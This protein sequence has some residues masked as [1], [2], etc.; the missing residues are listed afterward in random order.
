MTNK[1]FTVVAGGSFLMGTD[2]A[3]GYLEDGEGPVHEVILAPF[4]IAPHTVTNKEFGK[5]IKA[6]SYKTDAEK[7]GWSFVF[8]GFLPDNFP[9]TRSVAQT[10]W[11]RQVFGA[12]WNHP[13]GPQSNLKGRADHPVVHVSW[14]DAMNYCEWAGA[15]LP[16]EAE[17]EFAARGG[18]KQNRYPW[19]KEREP[20]GRHNM[21]VWQGKFPQENTK[22]DGFY[23]TA[24]VGSFKPNGY[25]L[26]QTT[27]NVW[28]W[29]SDWF[30]KNYYKNSP[31]E[32]PEGPYH[33]TRKVMRGGSFLCHDS[34]CFRYRVDARSS[35][36]PDASTSNL[37]FR[38][39]AKQD[40][41][42]T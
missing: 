14:N 34:Y 28:E 12:D 23:G 17:W 15:R 16:T 19:G 39:V 40:K 1:K 33:G 41:I 31:K 21:N 13:E 36:E 26:Y 18:L 29:C 27:G 9:P 24:P 7:Y 22:A 35:N 2:A 20:N 37:G 3:D 5:F 38:I 4:A 32:N 6:T 42:K 25:G 8:A 11:W 10:P 30:D